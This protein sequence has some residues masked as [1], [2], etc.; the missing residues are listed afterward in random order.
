MLL[1]CVGSNISEERRF[2]R[3]CPSRKKKAVTGK[4]NNLECLLQ[5][6]IIQIYLFYVFC[7]VLNVIEGYHFLMGILRG[8]V[9]LVFV[10]RHLNLIG[11]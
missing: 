6:R 10:V 1:M 8:L 5:L 7:Q 11:I 9:H 3:P 4:L 2:S